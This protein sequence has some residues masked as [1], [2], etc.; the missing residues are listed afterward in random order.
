VDH[1]RFYST[2]AGTEVVKDALQEL[3]LQ[4][5][6]AINDLR[7][8]YSKDALL[9]REIE[10]LR[11]G[12]FALRTTVDGME[13]RLYFGKVG[14]GGCI[15]LAVHVINKKSRK[16]PK[17]DLDLARDRLREWKTRKM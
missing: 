13:L 9:P 12:L 5:K 17:K 15:C 7:R 14:K 4:Q 8:R 1:W 16:V 3:G 10:A 2:A 11:K 6:A